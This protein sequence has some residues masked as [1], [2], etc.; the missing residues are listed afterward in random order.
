MQ[1]KELITFPLV[2]KKASHHQPFYLEGD[3]CLY[4]LLW[5]KPEIFYFGVKELNNLLQQGNT[6]LCSDKVIWFTFVV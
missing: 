4:I 3:D 2:A 5:L 1:M 6:S